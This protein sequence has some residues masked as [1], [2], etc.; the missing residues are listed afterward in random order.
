MRDTRTFADRSTRIKRYVWSL[1]V[2]W[3]VVVAGLLAWD[4]YTVRQVTWDLAINEARTHFEEDQAFR[5]WVSTHGGVYVPTDERTPPNPYLARVP[6]RDIE[7]PSGRSLTLMNPEYADRQM[8]EDFADLYG[9]AGH[10]T[11]LNPLR[12]E[13]APDSWERAAL[14]AFEEKETEVHEF[15]EMDGEP[16]LRFMQPMIAQESCLKCHGH[17]GYQVGD[18]RGGISV[19]VPMVS[20][21]AKE[22]QTLTSHILTLS[23]LWG[24]GLAG[25]GLASR[26][27]RQSIW[28]RDQ[29][30]EAL[31]KYSER[32]EQMVDERTQELR[33]AQDLL[34]RREK[35]AALGQLAGGMGHDL[36]NPLGVI[37]NTI[38]LLRMS[39]PDP[40]ETIQDCLE[41]IS[42]EVGSATK[43]VSDLLDFGRTVPADRRAVFVSALVT[44]ALGKC[45]IPDH[46]QVTTDLPDDLPDAWVDPYQIGSRCW[47]T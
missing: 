32:L 14:E 16:Y 18:V 1:A 28:E 19:S 13:N 42:D 37:S 5:L 30:Q 22:R 34:V 2:A 33:D 23:L 31:Q 12:P 41:M 8:H 26:G 44:Q 20:Y 47:S 10:L 21:L 6:E 29:A 36:R 9:V 3:T 4:V 46:V 40:G 25:L 35:L 7:T 43:I 15:A 17:Q 27:L 45:A 11:S 39:L 38:Y 24:L